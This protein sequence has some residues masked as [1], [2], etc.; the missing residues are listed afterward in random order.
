MRKTGERLRSQWNYFNCT[1]A[2]ATNCPTVPGELMA[3]HKQLADHE[4]I[5]RIEV[6]SYNLAAELDD[7]SP[8]NMLART[9]VPFAVATTV[10]TGTSN[11]SLERTHR[12]AYPCPGKTC[13]RSGGSLHDGKTADLRPHQSLFS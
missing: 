5:D 11:K 10:V 8:L 4:T 13:H 7:Q 6:D 1:P 9:P 3:Q 12:P 2:A